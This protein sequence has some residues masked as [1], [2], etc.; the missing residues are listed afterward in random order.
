MKEP[1]ERPL[2]TSSLGEHN[3]GTGSGP[4]GA[5]FL[6]A[7]AQIFADDG[8]VAGAGF[9][10]GE[11]ILVTCAHVVAAAGHG[12]ES[13]IEVGFPQLPGAPRVS[14]SVIAEQWRAPEEEDIAFVRLGSIP[15]GAHE[16]PLGAGA[17][18]RGHR[19]ASFGFP[20][21]A[22]QGGHFGYGTVGGLLRAPGGVDLLQLTG[23]ND[24]TTG[25][26]GG[27][28]VDEVTGLVIGMVTSITSPDSHL[29]GLGIAYCT[30][31]EVLRR[32][33][34]Q[35]TER[36]VR[37]YQGLEPF[38]EEHAEWFHGRDAA[39]ESVLAALG[40]EQRLLLVLGPSGAG[41]SSL[42]QAGVLPAL[43]AG[44]LPGSD[45]W[46]PLVARPG[47][48][49]N[50]E[51][52]RAGL[53]GA[54]ADGLLAAAERRLSREPEHDRLLVILDQFEELLTQQSPEA[55][56]SSSAD[57]CAA[58][59]EQLLALCDGTVAVTVMLVM[60][61]DFYSRLAALAPKLLAAVGAGVVN[62]PAALSVPEL[63]AI[64]TQP[65]R[66]AGAWMED[67][68][69]ERIITDVLASTPGQHAPVTLLP[70]LELALSQMWER[71][72]DGR[73]TH[74][75]YQRIG[76]VTGSLATW[77]N[78]ALD[79]LP[80]AQRPTARR[81]L[82]ALVRP[83]D[84]AHAIPA[85]RHQVS[86][87]RLR[88]LSRD[89]TSGATEAD[90]VF[91]D[92]LAALTRHRI[93]TTGST[94]QPGETTGEPAAEL[95]HDALVRDWS[96]LRTWVAL[97]RRFQV[98]LHRAAEQAARHGRSGRSDD[99][100]SG[101]ALAEGT[102]WARQRSLPVDAEALLHASQKHQQAAA[103]RTRR[104]NTV[105]IGMLVLALT[106]TGIAFWQRQAAVTAQGHAQA[107]ELASQSAAL[108]TTNPDLASLLAIEAHRLNPAEE[109]TASLYKA[110]ELRL[111]RRLPGRNEVFKAVAFSPDGRTLA[112]GSVKGRSP[113]RLWD[114]V[115]G[116][117]RGGFT[118][119]PADVTSL[120][121]S[122]DGRSLASTRD[123]DA[124]VWDMADRESRTI[125]KGDREV[126][127]TSVTFSPDG[128]T[129][130]IVAGN[131]TVKL[132][133]VA[134][135]SLRTLSGLLIR[136]SPV[137]SPDSKALA[138]VN[139][140]NDRLEIV[141]VESGETRRTLGGSIRTW[142]ED[143]SAVAFSP[144]G[145]S[146]AT[147]SENGIVRLWDTANGK[148]RQELRGHDDVVN[149]VAFSPDGE[150][151]AS[152][153]GDRTVRLWHTTSG[154]AE[155]TLTDY[156]GA[157]WALAF[158][159]DSRTLASGSQDAK[160]RLWD[161]STGMTR[162]TFRGHAHG[163]S[164]VAFNAD[165][166]ILYA[167]SVE[168]AGLRQWDVA[169]GEARDTG[170][171]ISSGGSFSPDGRTLAVG[172]A[173]EGIAVFDGTTRKLRYRI[174][175]QYL[176]HVGFSPDGKIIAANDTSG[177]AHTWDAATGERRKV[178]RNPAKREDFIARSLKF[179]SDG[180]MIALGRDDGAI[181]IWDVATG[182]TRFTLKQRE[183]PLEL[184]F[185]SDGKTLA[186][187]EGNVVQLWDTT[188]GKSQGALAGHTGLVTSLAFS[189]DGETLATGSEDA[190]AQL[191]DVATQEARHKLVGHTGPVMSVSFSPDGK[192]LATGSEDTTAMVW[193]TA[194]P[195]VAESI[196]QL[197][198]TVRRNLTPQ[199]R[200]KYLGGKELAPACPEYPTLNP[201][202]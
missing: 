96:D 61:D 174:K 194:I 51:L 176:M 151:L 183:G 4:R 91:D 34:P 90:V 155:G 158:S 92:V 99:L 46:L 1:G 21:Q 15:A 24:L 73:L 3:G 52:Q 31:V 145:R 111:K 95:I 10:V 114:A 115:T 84:E 125:L 171:E 132:W 112:A 168:P 26:S 55:A 53:P 179:S 38:T 129:L 16:L 166:T 118:G 47:T 62:V 137:F 124:V 138:V 131:G 177:N 148:S 191:W 167:D 63:Q 72:T 43:T 69:P 27:P 200:K 74:Q 123:K 146:L 36:Q 64:I 57:L 104:I 77:C 44:R 7:V 33:R 29:K 101:T 180:K 32:A 135:E 86:L 11:G 136:N 105:L 102:E 93:I 152:A 49:I 160:I 82:T 201:P 161:V 20:S 58:V 48:D 110:A 173:K 76:G 187:T 147:G 116:R 68:L 79:Q 184:A 117:S 149:A 59:T 22:P 35:L 113:V 130:V 94:P 162:R 175:E 192:Y 156:S 122:P 188:T 13:R 12:P 9:L 88:A 198:G 97:D 172:S 153:G 181:C 141:D 139:S 202:R 134:T 170:P 186:A 119:P 41:K 165:G 85:T 5:G 108:L 39:V 190:T 121:F 182:E 67:G 133:D 87:A 142:G 2:D 6:T 23:A 154:K 14:G 164:S 70:P 83:A 120:S 127:V 75:A 71:R 8:G 50:A 195:G 150:R 140:L 128:K 65:V 169:R 163:V 40:G 126:P 107:G 17:G 197:C 144:D 199:E 100:L 45:R 103:R 106:A 66:S 89:P 109:S 98:W 178:Y 28:V 185:S 78:I 159:P 143:Y 81:M 42:V 18:G 189:P 196:K 30:P 25:F 157:V 60:R 19:V 80:D 193:D 54:G 56:R 37:P